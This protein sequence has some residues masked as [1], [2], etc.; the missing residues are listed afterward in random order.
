MSG[1]KLALDIKEA[2][3]AVSLSPWTIRKWISTGKIRAIHLGRRVM[4][5]PTELKRLIDMGRRLNNPN[6]ERRTSADI[7]RP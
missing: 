2:A 1:T 6:T 3:Q 4:I 5:E 7:L